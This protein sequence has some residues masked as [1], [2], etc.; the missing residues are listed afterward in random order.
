MPKRTMIPKGRTGSFTMRTNYSL[1][2][3]VKLIRFLSG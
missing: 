3:T 2:A 1:P